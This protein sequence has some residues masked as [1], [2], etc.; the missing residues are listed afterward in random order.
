MNNLDDDLSRSSGIP[1]IDDDPMRIDVSGLEV[2]AE[3]ARSLGDGAVVVGV[4]AAAASAEHF[5]D[6]ATSRAPA[7]S[8]AGDSQRETS[9]DDDDDRKPSAGI[10]K[11]SATD[12]LL[13]RGGE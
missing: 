6:G 4:L 11:P 9:D 8:R 10:A 5:V 13:G 2:N 3:G 1:P 7:R 12:V